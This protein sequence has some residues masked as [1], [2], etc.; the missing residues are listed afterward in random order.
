MEIVLNSAGKVSDDNKPPSSN[1]SV[2]EQT[3]IGP[4]ERR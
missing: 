4:V 3:T 1:S 2:G